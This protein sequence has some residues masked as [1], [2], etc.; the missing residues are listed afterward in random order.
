MNHTHSASFRVS[1]G[2]S[3]IRPDR[4]DYHFIKTFGAAAPDPTTLPTT[5]SNYDGRAIPNQN[6][7]DDRFTPPLPPMPMGCT[8]ETGTFDAGIQDGTLYD[9][10][11]L[12]LNTPPGDAGGRDIR[13]M[14][15][16]LIERGPRK[17]DGTP[18]PHRTVYFN[19]YGS[20]KIDD[21]DAAR[22]ALW[23]NQLEKRNVIVGT[24]WYGEFSFPNN[25]G[26]IELPSFNTRQAGLHCYLITGWKGDKLEAIPWLGGGYGFGGRIYVSREIYNAL[27]AQPWTAAFTI[28]KIGATEPSTLGLKAQIDH[29]AYVLAQFVR[30]LWGL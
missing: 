30:N 14:L 18:G 24:W 26:V 9:P 5:F 25:E 6:F 2:L 29:I 23:I 11:D 21:F 28:S 1:E 7:P 4:R 22:I 10:Q 27:M 20:G 19:V 8:G 13:K 17:A 15:K 16:V 3:K 12:Y